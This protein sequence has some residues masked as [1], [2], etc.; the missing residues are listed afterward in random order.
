MPSTSLLPSLVL[1]WPSNCGCGTRSE[2]T[3]VSP[4]RKS[5]PEGTRSLNRFSFL[6]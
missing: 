3:A 4:S 1:V 5:S 6:P 2:M